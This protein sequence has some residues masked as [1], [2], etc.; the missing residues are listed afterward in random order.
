MIIEEGNTYFYIP[1]GTDNLD[2]IS[3]VP[4]ILVF[5]DEDYTAESAKQ[6]AINSGLAEIASQEGSI[7]VFVNAI[8]DTWSESDVATYLDVLGLFTENE[9]LAKAEKD[10]PYPGFVERVYVYGEGSG[11]NFV[12]EHLAKEVILEQGEPWGPRDLTPS[13][14]TLFNNTVLPNLTGY[15]NDI[16]I[17]AVNSVPGI[18]DR[19]QV[20]NEGIGLY[21]VE[22]TEAEGFSREIILST[23][24]EIGGRNRRIEG[25]VVQ[26]PDFEAEGIT[27]TIEVKEL[28]TGSIKYHQYIPN[29]LDMNKAGSVPLVMIYHGGGNTGEFHALTSDWPLIGKKK[30]FIVVSVDRHLVN[31]TEQNIELLELLFEE[32][33]AIDQ[34]RVYA[35]GFSMG[36][37]QSWNLAAEFPQYFAGIA[38]NGAGM[39]RK[40]ELDVLPYLMPIYYVGGAISPL[41]ELPSKPDPNVVDD[42]LAFFLKMNKIDSNYQYDAKAD[43]TW[44]IAPTETV[45]TQDELLGRDIDV[46]Y[47]RSEDNQI[48]TALVSVEKSHLAYGS[49]AWLAWEFL[50][51]FSR[52]SDGS[53]KITR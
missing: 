29:R 40:K 17:V 22:T 23:Y 24:D 33:P 12:A 14:I 18:E 6:T 36:A 11:A 27:E 38:P 28:S 13:F 16:P 46:S 5:G 8:G 43:E 20:L 2:R 7:V 32:Y 44:G 53:I 10:G 48:Y 39:M 31:N 41:A 37:V 52:A 45:S 47:F 42:A 4:I 26:L 9:R 51:K 25:V 19:L 3:I 35:S 15:E 30:G 34:T 49:D 50:S 1:E 21:A